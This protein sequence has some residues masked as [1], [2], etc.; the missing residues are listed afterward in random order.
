MSTNRKEQGDVVA[1]H[2]PGCG[3]PVK[4][5]VDDCAYCGASLSYKDNTKENGSE[6]KVF[7]HETKARLAS[8][9]L[10]TIQLSQETLD[11]L[12]RAGMSICRYKGSKLEQF[13]A[14]LTEVAVN[15][16]AILV[17]GSGNHT[18][19]EQQ[20]LQA[21]WGEQL[22]REL[23]VTDIDTSMAGAVTTIAVLSKLPLDRIAPQL[24]R[25]Q[26][27]CMIRTSTKQTAVLTHITFDQFGK[28]GSP[29]AFYLDGW[30]EPNEKI[31]H[32]GAAAFVFPK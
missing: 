32:L 24:D 18:A 20:A 21:A 25:N 14:R 7:S 6:R 27:P 30:A 19:S 10:I 12:R 3:A 4:K 13:R 1:L 22:K 9:G 2:C 29:G 15:P 26:S 23:G 31:E 28:M 8:K 5:G 11:D 16:D 17:A